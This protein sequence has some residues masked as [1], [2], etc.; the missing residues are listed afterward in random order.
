[1]NL[2]RPTDTASSNLSPVPVDKLWS[3][4]PTMQQQRVQVDAQ[5]NAIAVPYSQFNPEIAARLVDAGSQIELHGEP[6]MDALFILFVIAKLKGWKGIAIEG[7]EAFRHEAAW[8]AQLKELEL[9]DAD[10]REYLDARKKEEHRKELREA[11]LVYTGITAL[12]LLI[13][14]FV[15]FGAL[16]AILHLL[17]QQ[18]LYA[19][20]ILAVIYLMLRIMIRWVNGRG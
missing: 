11:V 8:Y 14:S 13:L 9:A 10:L 17:Q 1:M 12:V 7:D 3:Q 20:P 6:D 15:F 18:P 4:L 16:P 19:L 2:I 5:A